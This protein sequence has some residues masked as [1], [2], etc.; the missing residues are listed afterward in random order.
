MTD[1]RSLRSL[2]PFV[3]TAGGFASATAAVL[4][5]AACSG[6]PG[7][8]G[9]EAAD[10]FD[11]YSAT[12]VLDSRAS[13]AIPEL[14]DF[15][16]GRRGPGRSGPVGPR[17]PRGSGGGPPGGGGVGPPAGAGIPGGGRGAF[18]R[19]D[20]E[21]SEALRAFRSVAEQR[22]GRITLAL[23]DSLFSAKTA[24]GCA[25]VPMDGETVDL[26][27]REW[28]TTAKLEWEDLAPELQQTFGSAGEI[29]TRFEVVD[30]TR[31]IVTRRVRIGW[32]DEFRARFIYDREEGR[33]RPPDGAH[34]NP[35][36]RA[37]G[38]APPTWGRDGNRAIPPAFRPNARPGP[39][40]YSVRR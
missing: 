23:D 9:P 28:A 16:P 30:R 22:P 11:E 39:S 29:V 36:E 3:Q 40:V 24:S 19:F 14:S 32:I 1:A 37:L 21:A 20:P 17:P 2:R 25:V 33:E 6:A 10:L 15:D 34:C 26:P 18:G 13:D 31:L 5:L 7:V 27:G 35:E 8:E 4:V 12:W 38:P